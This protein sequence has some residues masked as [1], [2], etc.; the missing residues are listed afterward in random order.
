MAPLQVRVNSSTSLPAA[1]TK[2]TLK[3]PTAAPMNN[4]VTTVNINNNSIHNNNNCDSASKPRVQVT[5]L[6][7]T[8][9]SSSIVSRLCASN[10]DVSISCR[11]ETAGKRI[12]PT[13]AVAVDTNR[14]PDDYAASNVTM[15]LN[16]T[17]AATPKE[18]VAGDSIVPVDSVMPVHATIV[19]LRSPFS[20]TIHYISAEQPPSNT[21]IDDQVTAVFVNNRDCCCVRLQ[22]PGAANVATAANADKS[23]RHAAA[24]SDT[25]Y[26]SH[27]S[28]A[29]SLAA[30]S[31]Q[32][33][34]SDSGSSV[35]MDEDDGDSGYGV[36]RTSVSELDEGVSDL[37]ELSE[38]DLIHIYSPAGTS[39]LN[40]DGSELDGL[41][42]PFGITDADLRQLLADP[43]LE[44][45]LDIDVPSSSASDSGDVFDEGPTAADVDGDIEKADQNDY[46]STPEVLELLGSVVGEWLDESTSSIGPSDSAERQ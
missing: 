4:R 41:M 42:L 37:D 10:N 45:L 33:V 11:S 3:P 1:S 24:A 29:D 28:D 36:S 21:V 20:Q 38:D 14:K 12:K 44:P 43:D 27:C 6:R 25:C 16:T 23:A 7:G 30:V 40:G 39:A 46:Y 18:T 31:P 17:P 32:F 34:Q 19:V 26:Q 5:P 9:P 15:P 8:A 22:I 2:I 35:W 13:V